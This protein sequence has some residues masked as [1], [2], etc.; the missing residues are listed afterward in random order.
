MAIHAVGAHADYHVSWDQLI[1]DSYRLAARVKEGF[2]QR[3]LVGLQDVPIR[4]IIA[5]SRGGLFPAAIIATAL[6][7]RR[8]RAVSVQSYASDRQQSP[9]VTIDSLPQDIEDGGHG[10]LVI[11]DIAASG[12]TFKV[13]RWHWPHARYACLYVKSPG[14]AQVNVWQRSFSGDGWVDLPWEVRPS[15]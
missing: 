12:N 1:Q 5:V 15:A 7:I 11:D 10:W 13:L 2:N 9:E 4:G 8:V 6:E 3:P 14:E